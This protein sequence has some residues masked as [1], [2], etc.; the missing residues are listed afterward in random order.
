MSRGKSKRTAW[1]S[2]TTYKGK[3][4]SRTEGY[5]EIYRRIY[6]E[7]TPTKYKTNI[8]PDRIEH[9]WLKNFQMNL[10]RSSYE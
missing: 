3:T 1:E 7:N 4:T 6:K 9:K 2:P 10:K 8:N 5:K